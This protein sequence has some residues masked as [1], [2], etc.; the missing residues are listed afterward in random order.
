MM[1]GKSGTV[2]V[3]KARHRLTKLREYAVAAY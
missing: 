3:V 2:R 1:R